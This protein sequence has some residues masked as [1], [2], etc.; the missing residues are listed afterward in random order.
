MLFK[1]NLDERGRIAE[2]CS[3][4]YRQLPV[5]NPKREKQLKRS[6]VA[7]LLLVPILGIVIASELHDELTNDYGYYPFWY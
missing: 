6:I 1:K 7:W 4:R 2:P 5:D 3:S